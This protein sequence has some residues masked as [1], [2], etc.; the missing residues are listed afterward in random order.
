DGEVGD[1]LPGVV[2]ERLAVADE[3]GRVRRD[4]ADLDHAELPDEDLV[5]RPAPLAERHVDDDPLDVLHA[6]T[7][8]A[9]RIH[10]G[11]RTSA[12]CRR[13]RGTPSSPS[14]KASTASSSCAAT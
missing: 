3:A 8:H 12:T 2:E 14:A 11:L 6:Q 5:P 4:A 13:S 1:A 9:A 7:C 10:D